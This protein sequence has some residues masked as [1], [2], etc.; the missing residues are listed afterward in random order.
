MR[1][2]LERFEA[3]WAQADLLIAPPLFHDINDS[4]QTIVLDDDVCDGGDL[5]LLLSAA[6]ERGTGSVN[7]YVVERFVCF[8]AGGIDIGAGIAGMTSGIPS[9]TW[10]RGLPQSGI[11][12]SSQLL[13][14]DPDVFGTVLAHEVGHFLGLYHSQENPQ[15]G[16]RLFDIIDDTGTEPALARDNLMYFRIEGSADISAGQASVV[17]RH[18][19][20]RP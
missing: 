13:A 8:F 11:A 2:A 1:S 5:D 12:I 16:V 19:A 4:F 15:S 20:V 10:A 17:Q 3:L 7:V 6:P 14:R 18:L 9:M